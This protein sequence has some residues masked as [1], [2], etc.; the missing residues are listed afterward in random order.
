MSWGVRVTGKTCS[1]RFTVRTSGFSPAL[2]DHLG[3]ILPTHHLL[4]IHRLHLVAFLQAGPGR[5][6]NLR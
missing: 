1:P 5:R 6:E 3:E 4:V 2:A